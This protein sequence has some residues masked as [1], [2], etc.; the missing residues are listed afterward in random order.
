MVPIV[1]CEDQAFY[2]KR[3]SVELEQYI[4]M[5]EYDF[6]VTLVT[7]SPHEVV[8]ELSENSK[9]GI[10]FLDVD[11]QDDA[12]DGFSLGKEIRKRDPR[13]FI[14]YVTTHDELA[15][16]TFKYRVEALDY[17]IKDDEFNFV[18]RIHHCLD[19]VVERIAAE[20]ADDRHYYTIK[21]FDE[22]HHIPVEEIILIETASQQHRLIL[23]T[24]TQSLE[25]L[26][27]LNEVGEELGES[28]MRVHRSY[29][30]QLSRIKSVN[31]KENSI[32]LEGDLMCD[33]ARTKR[34]PLQ[35]YMMS[36]GESV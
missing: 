33:V 24:E 34:K 18:N 10:Y 30:V 28:F 35:A 5:T 6:K 12:Y 15:F 20:V 1:I 4:M 16:E 25:F 27:S 8:A 19:S 9:R 7:E 11:L 32:A 2:R 29:L 3:L 36:I 26:G 13:G 14:I 22:I 17:I 23:H 21:M 31:L